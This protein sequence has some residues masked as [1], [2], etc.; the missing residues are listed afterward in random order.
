MV[1][2]HNDDDDTIGIL[3]SLNVFGHRFM[4]L[5]LMTTRTMIQ[6]WGTE[7]VCALFADVDYRKVKEDHTQKE[8]CDEDDGDDDYDE[9]DFLDDE[10]KP[11]VWEE[12]SS[13]F[14]M[15]LKDYYVFTPGI[16]DVVEETID[17]MKSMGVSAIPEDPPD[18]PTAA[19]YMDFVNYVA[20]QQRQGRLQSRFQ[21]VWSCQIDKRRYTSNKIPLGFYQ[22]TMLFAVTL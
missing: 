13:A 11:N 20:G 15:V 18:A 7:E 12:H 17:T 22:G 6:R 3:Y 5:L 1:I 8:D 16:L 2:I 21:R 19:E 14:W 4:I 9:D 10:Y